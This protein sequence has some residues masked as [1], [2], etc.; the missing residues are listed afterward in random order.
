MTKQEAVAILGQA[1]MAVK[2]DWR[3]HQMMQ[4]ALKVVSEEP[5]VEPK[6]E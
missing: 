5:K 4:E 3:E 2:A 6:A 1:C